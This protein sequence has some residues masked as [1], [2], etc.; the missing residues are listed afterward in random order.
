MTCG[1][2]LAEKQAAGGLLS[3]YEDYKGFSFK[4]PSAWEIKKRLT[5]DRGE[6]RARRA[7]AIPETMLV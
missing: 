3:Q 7:G 5:R 2:P 1:L 4:D 6:Y